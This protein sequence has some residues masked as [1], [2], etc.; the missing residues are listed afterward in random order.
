MENVIVKKN[1]EKIITLLWTGDE[2]E[3]SY[4]IRLSEPGAS[5][6]FL[7]LLIGKETQSL[8]LHVTVSH[9]APQTSSKV[10]IKSALTESAKVDIE[11]LVKIDKGAKGTNA[12]LA[13]HLLLLSEKAKGRAVPSLEILENDIKAGHATTV[14]RLNEMEI[15]YLMS[16]GLSRQTS[17]ALIIGGF[18]QEMIEQFPKNLAE[19]AKKELAI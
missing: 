3:L 11:G 13:A 17:K 8:N 7:G 2:T 6:K 1:E 5:V 18:L 14:G 12:W 9:Q 15:F 19:L 16:R 10:I 4:D